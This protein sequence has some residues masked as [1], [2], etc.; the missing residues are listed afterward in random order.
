MSEQTQLLTNDTDD[1][2]RLD[3]QVCFALYAASNLLTGL[4][5]PLL[6]ELGLTFPQYLV[7]LVL[8]EKSPQSV[9]SLGQQLYLDSGT[10]TPLLKRM[11]SAG[12]VKRQR[13]ASDERR[14]L[15]E[16]TEQGDSLRASAHQVAN[17]LASGPLLPMTEAEAL[18]DGARKLIGVLTSEQKAEE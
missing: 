10:L 2:L 14:V 7:M 9:G 1:A 15:V 3:K 5:R 16:L 12:L 17:T 18:R 4:Y 6:A 13:D 11:E 8:W